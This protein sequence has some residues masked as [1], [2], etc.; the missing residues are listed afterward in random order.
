MMICDYKLVGLLNN[1][2][3]LYTV[4]FDAAETLVSSISCRGFSVTLMKISQWKDM[5]KIRHN[6]HV[7][8]I[9]CALCVGGYHVHNVKNGWIYKFDKIKCNLIEKKEVK[10]A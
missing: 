1:V 2:T 5:G 8:L 7:Q 4:P 10:S 3:P 9:I 6:P